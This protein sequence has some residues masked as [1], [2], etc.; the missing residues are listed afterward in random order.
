[1]SEAV[2][3][4]VGNLMIISI[5]SKLKYR[6]KEQGITIKFQDTKLGTQLATEYILSM[7]R[8]SHIVTIEGIEE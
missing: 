5:H 7:I 2:P 3:L 8:L 6:E 4:L 1:L